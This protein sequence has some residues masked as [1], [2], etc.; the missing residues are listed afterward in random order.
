[1]GKIIVK[2]FSKTNFPQEIHGCLHVAYKVAMEEVHASN[3]GYVIIT[4][5]ILKWGECLA[6]AAATNEKCTRPSF[7]TGG[8]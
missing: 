8:Q 1:M 7:F 4:L 3:S 6:R 2:F 5:R